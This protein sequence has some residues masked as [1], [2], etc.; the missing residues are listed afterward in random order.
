MSETNSR[1][2]AL[3][4]DLQAG[5]QDAARELAASYREHVLRCVR[6][7]LHQKMRQHC[8]SLDL[9][10]LV[11]ASVLIVP[12]RLAEIRSPEQFVRFLAGVVRNKVAHEGRRLR[13][14]KNDIT[15]Q[16]RF[17]EACEIAGP[18]PIS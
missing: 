7:S 3:L 1:F 13:A 11:W 10:Q 4:R 5:S 15:R 9:A 8:D 2:Q 14:I 18:H 12:Q 16:V 17:D 6:R